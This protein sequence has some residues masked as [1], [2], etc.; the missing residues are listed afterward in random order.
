ME[1]LK[2]FRITALHMEGFK[3]YSQPTD[4]SF[5]DPTV[6][7]GGNGRG[8]SSIADAIAFAVTG[9]PFFGEH[10]IDRLH[11]EDNPDLFIR[12]RFVDEN[13]TLHEL[14]RARKSNR[15]T[16]TYDGCE[17]RQVDLTDLFG[18]RDVFLSIFNPLYFIEELGND[19]K[20]LLQRH[21]PALTKE[22]ILA[23]MAGPAVEAL[24]DEPLLSPEVE[25][26]KLRETIRELENN[27]LYL[28]GQ[29]DM[30]TAQQQ[31]SKTALRELRE[32][33]DAL[34]N[35][36]QALKSKQFA[37]VDIAA[38]NDELADL[39]A[40]YSD[41]ANQR[42]IPTASDECILA[43]TQELTARKAAV[44]TPK[45]VEATAQVNARIRQL[46]SQYQQEKE[47][48]SQLKPGYQC[49]TCRRAVTAD[50]LPAMQNAFRTSIKQIVEAGQAERA[51]LEELQALEKKARD[52][53]LQF[54]KDDI[55][56]LEET[57]QEAKEA[58]E[59]DATR[60][61]A[62]QLQERM[63]AL[64]AELEFGALSQEE[65]DNLAYDSQID[66]M[67]YCRRAE[68]LFE[69]YQRCANRR[70]VETIC[71]NFLR[72]LESTKL[73]VNGHLYFVP[74]H[75]M[76]KV[77]IFED[78]VAE[79]SRLSRNQTHLMANSI[80]I[81]DDAKQRQK[82]TEEFYSAVKKEISEYQE[83]AD[84]FIK[85]GC[86]SPSVMDRWVLKIQSLEGKKQHY[87][88]VLR[89]ELDGL[90]DDFATLKLL[91]QELSFRAQTIRAKKAV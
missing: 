33:E 24:R 64:A 31:N 74:R 13:G 84:Y 22:D 50:E 80:Y 8:K 63:Q 29:Q 68:E 14:S 75:N 61:E 89:R 46:G 53:F 16:I 38:L 39:S 25:S 73:S 5:G 66:A 81:I 18:E 32:K 79:I 36:E 47:Q 78:F 19:G 86:Q 43:L 10:R 44:Y 37:G 4:L 55:A 83:R 45:Y 51:K 71:V 27:V 20:N 69:L 57:L 54:Q 49:P 34:R 56:K 15:M 76:E 7:T 58:A 90:D 23:Q 77:D 35:E 26:R 67:A 42:Q 40:R 2:S 82:M 87:E 85:S 48:C 60:P 11:S 52:T 30:T 91:S 65:Y 41:L 17:V 88:D 6:I 1:K 72:I 21:L 70:Q 3:S 28:T 59:P 9:L 62:Q 12:M